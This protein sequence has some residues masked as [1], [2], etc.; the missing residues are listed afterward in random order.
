MSSGCTD[1]P[2]DAFTLWAL[3]GIYETRVLMS[4]VIRSAGAA[5]IPVLLDLIRELATYER[6]PDAVEATPEQLHH[7]FFGPDANAR[8]LVAEVDGAP[9]GCAI[10]FFNFSTWTGRRGVYLEDLYVRPSAR[11]TGAGRALMA[12][13]AH[14]ALE[15]GCA[16]LDWA[17][18]DWNTPAIGFYERLGARRMD[19]WTI[20]R[21]D[22][23]ALNAMARAEPAPRAL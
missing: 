13:L 22:G 11:G 2:S 16:R 20:Y 14:I 23:S 4:L 7:A 6:E 19:D 8:G 10:Y 12:R 3:D 17:V 18:L 1:A 21:L 15:H 9:V 5:D